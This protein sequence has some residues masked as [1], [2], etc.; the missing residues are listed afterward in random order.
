MDE[1]ESR[2]TLEV[3]V[4]G[5]E[6]GSVGEFEVMFSDRG[7]LWPE[8]PVDDKGFTCTGSLGG[9]S[10]AYHP[11]CVLTEGGAGG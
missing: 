1:G 5:V 3:I 9:V 7:I 4:V 2:N 8:L 10:G 6:I 11:P